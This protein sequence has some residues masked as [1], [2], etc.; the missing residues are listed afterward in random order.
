MTEVVP[1]NEFVLTPGHRD[2]PEAKNIAEAA[3]EKAILPGLSILDELL[4]HIDTMPISWRYSRT[5][6]RIEAG[7]E[8]SAVEKPDSRLVGLDEVDYQRMS[9]RIKAETLQEELVNLGGRLHDLVMEVR[10]TETE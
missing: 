7:N 10:S 8:E 5:T 2:Y 4:S 1:S 3:T 6:V 9:L